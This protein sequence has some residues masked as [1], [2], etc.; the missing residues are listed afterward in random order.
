MCKV[1]DVRKEG[2]HLGAHQVHDG[3]AR[4][5]IEALQLLRAADATQ[6][7]SSVAWQISKQHPRQAVRRT[8]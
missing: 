5:R 6:D 3:P 4:A 8:L 1:L 2:V 7:G